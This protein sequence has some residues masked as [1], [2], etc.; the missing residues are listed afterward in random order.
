HPS[1]V[2]LHRGRAAMNW[3]I[4]AGRKE[5]G[6]T[7]FWVD[8]GIDTGPIILQKKTNISE[9]E[10]VGSI[11]F[12]ELYPMGVEALTEAVG[13]VRSGKAESIVQ[14]ESLA[15]YEGPCE[16]N[17]GILNFSAHGQIVHNTIRGCD[18]QPGASAQ[19]NEI[20]LK[21]FG[22]SY[23]PGGAVNDKPGTVVEITDGA[24]VVST[25]GGTVKI[26]RVQQPGEK[27]VAAGDVLRLGDVLS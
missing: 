4:L 6:L 10:T 8:E 7:I 18:P 3:A 11:Y 2:P 27:K 23:N 15:T 13:L 1:L 19:L 26:S 20:N 24:A 22:S 12:N 25:I 9:D 17:H 14:N 5:T 16:D 21:L